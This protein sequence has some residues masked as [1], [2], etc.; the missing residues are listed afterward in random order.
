MSP[1]KHESQFG[2]LRRE[3]ESLRALFKRQDRRSRWFVLIGGLFTAI[4]PWTTLRGPAPSWGAWDIAMIG[5]GVVLAVVFVGMLLWGPTPVRDMPV[6]QIAIWVIAMAMFAEGTFAEIYH[7]M[8]AQSP[9]S[10]GPSPMSGI[11]AA[12][13]AIGTA[14]TGSD[15]HP[16]SGGAR[17]LVSAQQIA[18]LFLIVI[19][20]TTAVGRVR[21]RPDY[22]PDVPPQPVPTGT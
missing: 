12:Y 22:A 19:A 16:V 1:G 7:T 14:T 20:I 6:S 2:E 13:F 18:S 3:Q 4:Y 17:L 5:L 10:F 21:S 9:H 15:I 8:S 11:D